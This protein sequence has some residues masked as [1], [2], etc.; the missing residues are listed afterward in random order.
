[1]IPYNYILVHAQLKQLE[2]REEKHDRI[3]R[4]L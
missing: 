1:M 4:I 2:E 3:R